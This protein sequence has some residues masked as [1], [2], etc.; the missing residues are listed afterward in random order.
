MSPFDF[1]ET[2]NSSK[3]DLLS[4]DPLLEKDYAPFVINRQMSYFYDTV[5]FA[6]E[7]NRYHDLPKKMQ[8]HFYLNGIR[9]GKRFAKWSKPPVK[10]NDLT[11]IMEVFGYNQKKAE[12]TLSILTAENLQEIRAMY[13]SGGRAK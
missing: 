12:T 7:M 13:A 2:I 3:E 10:T 4:E 6:N 8:Y 1:I 5:L 9:K 11:L